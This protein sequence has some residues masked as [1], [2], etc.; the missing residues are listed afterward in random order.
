M[1]S[2]ALGRGFSG[3]IHKVHHGM[4]RNQDGGWEDTDKGQWPRGLGET[5]AIF[6]SVPG[7][8]K[9]AVPISSLVGTTKDSD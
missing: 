3:A 5:I 8:L 7:E 4:R 6:C 9:E 2:T 1:F